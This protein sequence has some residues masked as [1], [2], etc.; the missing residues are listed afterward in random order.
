VSYLSEQ[1]LVSA[2]LN[3]VAAGTSVQTTSAIKMDGYNSIMY[4]IQLGTVLSTAV[5]QATAY[6]VATNTNSGGTA[7]TNGQTTS[8]TDSGGASSNGILIVDVQRQTSEYSYLTLTRTTANVTVNSILAILYNALN[9]PVTQGTT[10][11][12]LAQ[13][14]P[15]V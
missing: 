9:P 10:V 13:G 4:V 5:I 15:E 7:V 8:L 1:V 12:E 3:A 14:G 2:P 11:L 6:E